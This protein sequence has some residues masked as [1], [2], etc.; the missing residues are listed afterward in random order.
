MGVKRAIKRKRRAIRCRRRY[1]AGQCPHRERHSR[2]RAA[3]RTEILED[4]D[5]VATP[6][7]PGPTDADWFKPA[8]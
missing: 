5:G 2:D 4:G 3:E 8:F 6:G 7:L 1:G